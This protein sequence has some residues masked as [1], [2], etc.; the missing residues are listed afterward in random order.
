MYFLTIIQNEADA[1]SIF[2]LNNDI[3][4]YVAYFNALASSYSALKEGN[5]KSF[6]IKL[7]DNHHNIIEAREV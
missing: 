6:F 3:E 1:Q 5:I 2:R 4:A 7:E